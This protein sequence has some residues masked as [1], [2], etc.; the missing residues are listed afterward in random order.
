[1]SLL[2]HFAYLCFS[3][4]REN[5]FYVTLKSFAIASINLEEYFRSVFWG[6]VL[7]FAFTAILSWSCS[8]LPLTHGFA[9][10]AVLAPSYQVCQPE[11]LDPLLY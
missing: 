8:L 2:S 6:Q 4:Q 5:S 9:R 7:R 10:P 3:Y 11:P 1:M